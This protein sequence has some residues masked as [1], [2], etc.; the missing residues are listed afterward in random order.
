MSSQKLNIYKNHFWC[1]IDLQWFECHPA[2]VWLAGLLLDDNNNECP[3][4]VFLLKRDVQKQFHC[5]IPKW[6]AC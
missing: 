4:S 5:P 2:N 1:F 3:G 6:A